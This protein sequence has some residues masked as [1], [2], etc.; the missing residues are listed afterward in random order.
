MRRL[1]GDVQSA[2][3]LLVVE[4]DDGTMK[5]LYGMELGGRGKGALQVEREA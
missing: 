5:V 4:H 3:H 1:A 2:G